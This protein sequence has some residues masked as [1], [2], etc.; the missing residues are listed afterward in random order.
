MQTFVTL[1]LNKIFIPTFALMTIKDLQIDK[2]WTL[3]L[4]RDGVLNKK[5][6]DDYV[7]NWEQFEFLPGVKEA[8]KDLAQIFHRIIIVTNQRG[9]GRGLMSLE[10]L[11]A[12]HENLGFEVAASGGRIDAIYFCPDVSDEGSTHRKPQ[13]GM[14]LDAQKQFPEIDFTKSIIVGDSASDMQLGENLNMKKVLISHKIKGNPDLIFP[15]LIEFSTE[16]KS[17]I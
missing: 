3:F 9:V 15:A 7:R 4:D 10:A 17:N 1:S 12:I 6:D 2:T 16:L 5:I 13:P 11:N 8:L 14:A